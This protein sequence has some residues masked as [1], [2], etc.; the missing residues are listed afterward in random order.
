MH[1]VNFYIYVSPFSPPTF[2]QFNIS[3]LLLCLM[4]SLTFDW[5]DS[6]MTYSHIRRRALPC[7]TLISSG[8]FLMNCSGKNLLLW[9]LQIFDDDDRKNKNSQSV[10]DHLP[11]HMVVAPLTN[12]SCYEKFEQET[13]KIHHFAQPNNIEFINQVSTYIST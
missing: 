11:M 10:M 2:Q 6:G 9:K 5:L 1:L 8:C 13:F 3:Y 7:A 12:I 4:K